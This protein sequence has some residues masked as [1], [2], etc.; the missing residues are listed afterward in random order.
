MQLI[1]NNPYR[2]V[3]LL[4]GASAKEQVRQQKRL[5]QFIEAEQEPEDDFSFPTLGKLQRSIEVITDASSKLNLDHDKMTAALFWFYKGNDITD[6]PAFDLLKEGNVKETVSLW[7][8]LTNE[9]GV[10]SRNASAFHNLATL[11]LNY[12]FIEG[13][14]KEDLL[15]KG[16]RL[17]LKFLESDHV[18]DLKALA[19][20]ETFQTTKKELQ[21][22]FLKQVKSEIENHGGITSDKFL[23]ILNKQNFSAKEEFLKEF[24]LKPIENIEKKIEESKKKR[25]GNDAKAG[26]IGN[27]LYNSTKSELA[28]LKSIL[29]TSDFKF[30]SISDKLA[31][32]ILQCGITLFNHFHGTETE[33]GEIALE[34]NNKASIIALG[35]LVKERINESSPIVEKYIKG[36]PNREK[37]NVVRSELEFISS[38]IEEFQGISNCV[39]NALIFANAC[40]P[41]LDRMKH[42]LGLTDD[43]YISMSTA[44][45]ENAIGM[46]I[47]TVNAE[48]ENR[49]T[50]IENKKSTLSAAWS[51]TVALESFD[52]TIKKRDHYIKN[53]D[54]LK[55]LYLQ[56]DN[57]ILFY[58]DTPVK[59]WIF[60][61]GGIILVFCVVAGIWGEEGLMTLLTIMGFIVFLGFIGWVQNLN[62]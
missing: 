7:S 47:L 37:Q 45:L 48:I 17:K 62:R 11:M 8:K 52:M 19:T 53:K 3:G 55:S 27:E 57:S 4:V 56:I 28:L 26:S 18:K 61:V 51:A 54:S 20:D 59:K 39:S 42:R 15:E 5:K 14:I 29:G 31:N 41:Y 16:L 24:I 13:K 22:L 23:E 30:I 50:S 44:V 2:I 34:L 33:V 21:L 40:K 36:R 38:K 60:W 43:L 49:K 9:K 32:E 12:A 35:S 46:I 10:E 1:K 25:K 6:E 58:D